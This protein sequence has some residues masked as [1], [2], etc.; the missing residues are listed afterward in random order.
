MQPPDIN[1]IARK[2]DAL[3]SWHAS[4]V[5]LDVVI[6]IGLIAWFEMGEYMDTGQRGADFTLDFF[7]QRMAPSDGPFVGYQYVQ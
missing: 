1:N 6:R 4:T 3:V 7:N 2:K 5:E